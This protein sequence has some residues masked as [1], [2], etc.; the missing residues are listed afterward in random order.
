MQTH[1]IAHSLVLT[2]AGTLTIAT[3]AASAGPPPDI[4]GV[5][6]GMGKQEAIEAIKKDIPDSISSIDTNSSIDEFVVKIKDTRKLPFKV[7][8]VKVKICI[9]VKT[10]VVCDITASCE[11]TD[12][13]DDK[14]LLGKGRTI[15]G[16]RQKFG[17]E[18]GLIVTTDDIRESSAGWYPRTT[19]LAED[20]TPP[21]PVIGQ[22]ENTTMYW[23][24]DQRWDRIPKNK[25]D[26]NS[27]D[28]CRQK[29]TIKGTRCAI[30]EAH[31]SMDTKTK[32]T[33][34]RSISMHDENL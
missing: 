17:K 34:M 5:R 21:P 25:L 12:A 11:P 32:K 23:F 6:I 7:D 9:T 24:F 27:A 15:S 2:I 28:Q 1:P 26:A 4:L 8:T 19:G 30:V 18:S 10:S 14:C 33:T 16:I 3:G 20:D 31:I 13:P 22:E 29:G